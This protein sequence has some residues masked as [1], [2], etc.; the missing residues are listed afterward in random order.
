[1]S[2]VE[3]ARAVRNALNLGQSHQRQAIPGDLDIWPPDGRAS[4]PSPIRRWS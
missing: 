3:I 4:L 2:E 1:L